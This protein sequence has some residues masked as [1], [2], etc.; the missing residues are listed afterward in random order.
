MRIKPGDGKTFPRKGGMSLLMSHLYLLLEVT[1]LD[2]VQIHHAGSLSI[3]K[4][5]D[6]SRGRCVLC[7]WDV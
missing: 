4:L 7:S 2:R 5:F 3:G 1:S 6:S